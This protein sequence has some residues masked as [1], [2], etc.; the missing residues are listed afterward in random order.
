MCM[1]KN[2]R[3]IVIITG[4]TLFVLLVVLPA[5]GFC[6]LNWGILPPQKLT[7]LVEREANKL[8]NGRLACDKIELTFFE[9][10]P[11]L[12]VK[13]TNGRLISHAIR[14]SSAQTEE[15]HLPTDSL[16]SFA[17]ATVSVRPMD[18]LFGGR[19]TINKIQ[20]ETP[21]FYGYISPEGESNWDIIA[22]SGDSTEVSGGE[23]SAL[24]PF[25]LQEVH[26]ENGHF[27]YHDNPSD[28]YAEI[29]GFFL[30]LKGSLT[31]EGGNTFKVETGS[32]SILFESP[33]YTLSNNLALHLKSNMELKDNFQ[34][35]ILHDAEMMINQLPFT[36]DGT[37]T[38]LPETKSLGINMEMALTVSDMNDLLPFVPETYFKD[39]NSLQAN[40][41]VLLEG[42]VQGMLGDSIIPT[43]NLCCKIENGSLFMKDVKQGIES[44]E[45]DMDLHINGEDL[46]ASYVS[47]ETLK[48]NGLNTSLTIHG[49]VTDLLQSPDIDAYVKGNIDFS[50]IAEE[51]LHPDTLLLRGKMDANI[52]ASFRLED[53]IAGKY[54]NIHA[55]GKLDIDTLI[56]NSPSYGLDVFI[57]EAHFDIDS[58]HV[59]SRYIQGDKLLNAS[60]SI[61]SLNILYKEEINTNI[62]GLSIT[63]KTSPEIDTSAVISVTSHIKAKRLRTRLPDSTWLL[64]SQTYLQGGIRPSA[65]NK[66]MPN[67]VASISVDT[68]RYFSI[69]LRTGGT[70]AESRFS[71]E[72]LPIRDAMRQRFRQTNRDSTQMRARRDTTNRA[73]NRASTGRQVPDSTADTSVRLLRNWEVR[74]KVQFNQLRLFSRLFPLPMRM[75]KTT[76]QFNTDQIAFSDARFH[77]GKS[78]FILTGELSS[79]R[80]ALLRG[81]KLKGVFN[82]S[83]DYTDCDQLF[84]AMSQGLLFAEQQE[85]GTVTD[86]RLVETDV[87]IIQD[88]ISI[89]AADTTD[90]LFVVPEYLDMSLN[91]TANKLNYK[92][93][94]MEKV[95]GEIVLRNQ[96]INLKK[97]EMES[98]IG[99]GNL[100]MFYIAKDKQGASAGVDMEMRGILVEKLIDLYPAV[101]TLLPMLRSFEGIVDCQMSLTCDIDSTMSLLLPTIHTA[102]F[103]RGKDMVL[104]DGETFAEISK[105]LMFKNKKRNQIDQIAV[106][107]AIKDNKIEVFPFLLEMDRYRVAVGGTHNLDMTFDYHISVLKSPV[108]FK[109]GV[110]I[111]GNLEKPKFRITKCK[112]KNTFNPAREEELV[113][114]KINIREGIRELIRKQI[115]ENAPELASNDRQRENRDTERDSL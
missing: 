78:N 58:A 71:V 106:D 87:S 49:K 101:D 79:I 93:L 5:V 80:R 51:F 31:R 111:T 90:A 114:E 104:L 29:D 40:G 56:A 37:I 1:G 20:L 34:T 59:T 60:L 50:R 30:R 47:L 76:V 81:G 73:R 16:L 23:K 103:I 102:C 64:A 70:L 2:K 112:Y 9:T 15:R 61:D 107:L 22:G 53:L 113:A 6:I 89:Q 19:I 85:K 105:T 110:D 32:S 17:Q 52:E 75:E 45:M 39:F 24:P 67:L 77:A 44:L 54:N 3:K 7:P 109:L 11:H 95:V 57:T 12:G 98:N 65:S 68:L 42:T 88:S 100:T 21:R 92:E 94:E 86:E 84:Q 41:S 26:I 13:I 10:Y 25:D 108:P 69:P 74:G 97:L 18:Y 72:M 66:K 27:I 43:L 35:F 28:S 14:E 63:A 91:L 4:V 33:L 82:V 115:V 36:A 48:I 96:S 46:H 55:T 83:S 99:Q 8:L 38:S 62:S